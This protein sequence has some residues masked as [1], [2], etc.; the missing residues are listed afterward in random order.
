MGWWAIGLVS[1]SLRL[2]EELDS[3]V[4]ERLVSMSDLR[5]VA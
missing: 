3:A 5:T 4:F 2:L 1:F